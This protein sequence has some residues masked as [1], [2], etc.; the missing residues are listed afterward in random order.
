MADPT[1]LSKWRRRWKRVMVGDLDKEVGESE[2]GKSDG[3]EE[4]EI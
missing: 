4:G 2:G 1:R 3:C